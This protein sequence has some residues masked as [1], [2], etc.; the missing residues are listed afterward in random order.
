[1]AHFAGA[2]T[3]DARGMACKN[4][5]ALC[6]LCGCAL[7]GAREPLL[8]ELFAAERGGVPPSPR[9]P[10]ALSCRQRAL[11]AALVKRLP[12]APRLVRC[13]RADAMLR[14]HRFDAQLLRHQIR[15]QG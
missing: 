10:A 13:L 2:V 8:A 11:V 7:G 4:R 12:P 3:Y 15:T 1:M 5:D 9:R 14:P 6:R